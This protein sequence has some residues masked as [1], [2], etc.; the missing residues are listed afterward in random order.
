MVCEF[1]RL[2]FISPSFGLFFIGSQRSFLM[3]A[4]LVKGLV[5]Y[6]FRAFGLLSAGIVP[7]QKLS[8]FV[9]KLKI[10]PLAV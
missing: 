4:Q 6:H 2:V 7:I 9:R 8:Q 1:H 3:V 5:Q 10:F